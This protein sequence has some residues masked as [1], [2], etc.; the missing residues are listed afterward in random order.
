LASGDTVKDADEDTKIQV[1]EGSDDDTLDLTS[2]EQNW[3]K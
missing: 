3:S 1:E 2:Q